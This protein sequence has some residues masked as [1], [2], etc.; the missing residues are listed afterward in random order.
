LVFE[1]E[2]NRMF[3]RASQLQQGRERS[4]ASRAM[5]NGGIEASDAFKIGEESGLDT[6]LRLLTSEFRRLQSHLMA[7]NVAGLPKRHPDRLAAVSKLMRIQDEL[8]VLKPRVKAEHLNKSHAESAAYDRK[9][10]SVARRMLAAPV[11]DRLVTAT[12]HELNSD[13]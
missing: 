8:S 2:N 3:K 6:E 9:F 7:L 10:K 13:D 11:Y 12:L 5:T 1:K 4:L